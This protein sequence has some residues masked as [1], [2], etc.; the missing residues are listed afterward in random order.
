MCRTS[1]KDDGKLISYGGSK[2]MFGLD[3]LSLLI[4]TDRPQSDSAIR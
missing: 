4:P 1:L 3:L 2:V